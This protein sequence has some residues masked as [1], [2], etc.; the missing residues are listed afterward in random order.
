MSWDTL[1]VVKGNLAADVEL[2][3]TP[4][5]YAVANFTVVS[6]PRY[7]DRAAGEY[8]DG[9]PVFT[10]C[11]A[12]RQTAENLAESVRRGSRV[13]VIGRLKQRSWQTTDGQNRSTAEL[14]VDDVGPSLRNATTAIQRTR[15][16][17]TGNP[18]G[19]EPGASRVPVGAAAG[20]GDVWNGAPGF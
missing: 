17:D 13:I 10:R 8:R 4:A 18:T 6:T 11:T 12:W 9:E 3:F 15:Q 19:P 2:K 5:G 20:N 14:D 16:P 1:L 7:F